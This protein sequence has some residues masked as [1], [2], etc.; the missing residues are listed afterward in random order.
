[1]S[2]C[3]FTWF[4]NL[5][6]LSLCAAALTTFVQCEG[7]EPNQ[8]NIGSQQQDVRVCAAGATLKGIDIS[9]YQGNVD[10]AKIKADGISFAFVRVSDGLANPDSKFARNWSNMK[11]V[12]LIRGAYQF[13]RPRL[14]AAKQAQLFLDMVGPLGAD[15]LPPVIDVED[16]GGQS[17]TVVKQKIQTWIDIVKAATGRTPIIY[18]GPSFWTNDIANPSFPEYPLWIANYGVTCPE[19]PSTWDTWAFWQ[20]TDSGTTDGVDGPVDTNTFNGNMA[21]L[22]ALT[23]AAATCGD[24]QCTG[25]ETTENCAV[26]CPPCGVI[27]SAGGLVDDG[28]ACFVGGGDPMYLRKV[29]TN[30]IGGDLTWTYATD[31]AKEANSATWNL[32]LAEA[33]RYKVEVFTDTTYA[34]S[35]KTSYVVQAG[36]IAASPVV[37]DQSAFNGW[38]LIGEYD[39]AAAG[40]QNVHVGDNTGEPSAGKMQIALDAVRL[41]KVGKTDDPGGPGDGGSEAGCCAAGSDGRSSLMLSLLTLCVLVPRRRR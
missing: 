2:S 15:D 6:K 39:F 35:K 19:T 16:A 10:W 13:F 32:Y 4:S 12:G 5:L 38:Q 18:T 26:D 40:G 29:T 33:G 20:Y 28:D 3:R 22:L 24:N 34:Q 37:I 30:G 1:M 17:P 36:G 31:A 27:A 7:T 21:A 8:P 25:A 11:A 9:F 23:G 14:D 41:T